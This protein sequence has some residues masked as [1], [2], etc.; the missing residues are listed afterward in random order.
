MISFFSIFIFNT[1]L[2]KNHFI[3]IAIRC[4]V[5]AVTDFFA[6]SAGFAWNVHS[7]DFSTAV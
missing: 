7:K 2:K 1:V 3:L 5:P 4:I 6:L